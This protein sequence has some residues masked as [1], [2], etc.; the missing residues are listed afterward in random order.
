M[1]QSWLDYFRRNSW[2]AMPWDHP[3][4]LTDDEKSAVSASMQQFQLGEGSEGN[5]FI[6]RAARFSE[7]VE[8]IPTLRLFIQE[9]QRHSAGLARFLTLHGIPLLKKHWLDQIF[10]RIRRLA[11]LELIVTVLV[12]AEI[13]AVPYYRAL[14]NAT[15]A[16]L[17]RAL[18]QQILQDE[19]AHLQY[20][21]ETLSRLRQ[22]RSA[23]GRAL[24]ELLHAVLLQGTVLAVWM[25]HR[26]VLLRGG[27]SLA[28]FHRESEEELN[29][30]QIAAYTWNSD[31]PWICTSKET[32]LL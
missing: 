6:R 24:V 3:Y 8:F 25:E 28:K 9:E 26:R 14:H 19:A 10:R 5:A 16:P 18:C 12:S 31:P 23:I 15:G 32:S 20:Q 27:Y 29:T 11:G 1:T 4:R 2:P 17:L 21:A 30:V 7:D 22:G 13:V